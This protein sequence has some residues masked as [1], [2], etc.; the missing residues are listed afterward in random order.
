VQSRIR[1]KQIVISI[2][3]KP[4]SNSSLMTGISI[5]NPASVV[6]IRLTISGNVPLQTMALSEH[7]IGHSLN[8]D[9]GSSRWLTSLRR[10]SGNSELAI[11]LNVCKVNVTSPSISHNTGIPPRSR[12]AA[13]FNHRVAHIRFVLIFHLLNP[14]AISQAAGVTGY[15]GIS[16]SCNSRDLPA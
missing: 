5:N 2:S 11:I 3:G 4:A 1:L 8:C 16:L 14:Q 9:P 6:E 13:T 7:S 10:I 12:I 15:A